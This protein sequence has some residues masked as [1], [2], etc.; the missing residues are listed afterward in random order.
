MR[1]HSGDK[2]FKCEVEGCDK[3]Y[4]TAANL[5]LH[6]KRHEEK[7]SDEGEN[8]DQQHTPGIFCGLRKCSKSVFHVSRSV[9][10]TYL[11]FKRAELTRCSKNTEK[12]WHLLSNFSSQTSKFLIKYNLLRF[13]VSGGFIIFFTGQSFNKFHKGKQ[14][15][16][17]DI[18]D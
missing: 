12:Y 7:I 1:K 16:I 8:M 6:H 2:P 10:F 13:Q 9:Y 18:S 5:R 14:R 4:T 17:K 3:A 15:K 11:C